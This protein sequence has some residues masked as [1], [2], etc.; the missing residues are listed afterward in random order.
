LTKRI[1]SP[2]KSATAIQYDAGVLR[3][4]CSGRARRH[5]DLGDDQ[6]AHDSTDATLKAPRER[7]CCGHIA[8][9]RVSQRLALFFLDEL[10]SVFVSLQL[11]QSRRDVCAAQYVQ[12]LWAAG[13][14]EASKAAAFV[15]HWEDPPLCEEPIKGFKKKRP[16]D[17]KMALLPLQLLLA[18]SAR[19]GLKHSCNKPTKCF[20]HCIGTKR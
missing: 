18:D 5:D 20:K 16:L 10:D 11:R 3:I 12:G 6:R 9:R 7:Q 1:I 15:E 14:R 19:G 2:A 13:G 8:G 17:Q 4:A